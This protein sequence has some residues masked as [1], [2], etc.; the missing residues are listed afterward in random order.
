MKPRPAMLSDLKTPDLKPQHKN[1]ATDN[2]AVKAAFLLTAILL[3]AT[4]AGWILY[5]NNQQKKMNEL[6][7]ARNKKAEELKQ[8]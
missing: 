2:G 5:M 3:V 4:N 7:I 8:A 6:L 1:E